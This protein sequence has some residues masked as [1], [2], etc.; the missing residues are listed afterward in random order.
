MEIKKIEFTAAQLGKEEKL[1]QEKLKGQEKNYDRRNI[2][3]NK[4]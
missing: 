3:K 2:K 4:L 1:T